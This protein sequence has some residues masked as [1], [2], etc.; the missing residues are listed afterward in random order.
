MLN[1][2]PYRALFAKRYPTYADE[3]Y[4]EIAEMVTNLTTSSQLRRMLFSAESALV[5]ALLSPLI[6]IKNYKS[7]IPFPSDPIAVLRLMVKLKEMP[8]D[9]QFGPQTQAIFDSLLDIEGFQLPTVSAV[10]HFCHPAS[11]PIVDQNIEQ[12]CRYVKST[13]PQV[14]ESF[15]LPQLP[16]QTTSAAN[17]L[18]KYKEFIAF[19]DN[20]RVEHHALHGVEWSFREIDKALMVLGADQ[21]REQRTAA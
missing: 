9:S 5:T 4:A 10:F 6:K 7:Q 16:A 14:F 11:F 8:T 21:R 15:T 1:L 19:L 3:P 12:A 17:K 18:G 2:E 13:S 20:L